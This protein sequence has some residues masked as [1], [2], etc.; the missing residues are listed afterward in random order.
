LLN[1]QEKSLYMLIYSNLTVNPPTCRLTPAHHHM[2]EKAPLFLPDDNEE[3]NEVLPIICPQPRPHPHLAPPKT[4]T[5]VI[6]IAA[7]VSTVIPS[8]QPCLESK[9][10]F[11]MMNQ[12]LSQ[13]RVEMLLRK[14]Y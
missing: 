11:W 7:L 6:F 12:A 2:Q 5:V 1:L 13:E 3:E 9:G 8:Q 14:G 4:A 10:L